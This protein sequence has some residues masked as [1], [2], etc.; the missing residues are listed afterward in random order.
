MKCKGIFS[1]SEKYSA[2]VHGFVEDV[3]SFRTMVP[4]HVEC[5]FSHHG[6]KI[7][8]PMAHFHTIVRK[9][10]ECIF[11][12]MGEKCFFSGFRI[13]VSKHV[14]IFLFLRVYKYFLSLQFFCAVSP[15]QIFSLPLFF[16]ITFPLSPFCIVITLVIIFLI[17]KY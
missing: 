2:C 10:V 6:A 8:T 12:C 17:L 5:I 14:H 13:S 9:H 4:K 15:A 11:L 1:P 3:T 16:I 7:C